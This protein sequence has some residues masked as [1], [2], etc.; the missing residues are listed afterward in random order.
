[1]NLF[2]NYFL[3]LVCIFSLIIVTKVNYPMPVADPGFDLR[4]GVDFVNGGGGGVKI[5]ESV[6]GCSQT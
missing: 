3:C 6:D 2:V 4:G 5:I 1:M